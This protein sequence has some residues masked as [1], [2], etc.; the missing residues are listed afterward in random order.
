MEQEL[1][2]CAPARFTKIKTM[3]EPRPKI[4]LLDVSDPLENWSGL[5]VRC[6]RVLNNAHAEFM[7][8]EGYDLPF[9]TLR[10][11]SRCWALEPAGEEK[12]HYVY[13]LVEGQTQ[14]E[15]RD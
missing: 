6:G 15:G 7:F 8:V 9:Q 11:C 13:G 2:P 12:R 4:H 3:K 5:V 14:E 10:S 1:A